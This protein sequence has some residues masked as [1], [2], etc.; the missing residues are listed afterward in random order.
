MMEKFNKAWR[1][2]K[3][4]DFDS[5]NPSDTVIYIYSD[6][7]EGMSDEWDSDLTTDTEDMIKRIETDVVSS[8]KPIA[9]R[10]MTCN[11]HEDLTMIPGPS[12]SWTD[13]ELTP[14]VSK[15]NF[16]KTLCNAPAKECAKKRI[17]LSKTIILVADSPMSQH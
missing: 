11:S 8:P 1:L 7:S 14:K 15:Q 2:F 13:M 17:E 10:I 12:S 9:G 4:D 6:E 3:E 16:D 5:E